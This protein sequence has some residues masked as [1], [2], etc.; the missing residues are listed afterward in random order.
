LDGAISLHRRLV[1][2]LEKLSDRVLARRPELRDMEL[3]ARQELSE[4]LRLH[5][6][7]AE[8]IEVKEV[9]LETH[10]ERASDWRRDL[11]VLR[12]SKGEVETGL[13]ELRT[14][15]EEDPEDMWR[16]VA[17]G[18]ESRREGRFAESQEALDQALM[19]GGE[20]SD[21]KDLASVHYQRFLLFKEMGSLDDAVAAWDS[22]VGLEPEVGST[23]REVYDML[24]SAGRFSE[25]RRYVD[26]DDNELQA[27]FQR[28]LLAHL[29]GSEAQ[30]KREWRAVAELDPE[31]FESGHD[32]WAEA[33]LRLGDPE[34][35]LERMDRLLGRYGSARLSTMAGIAW[36]MH[37]DEQQAQK[38]FD[39]TIDILRRYRPPKHKLDS[40]DWRLLDSLVA[41]DELKRVLKPYFAVVETIWG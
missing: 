29:S 16:W 14:L 19:L 5:G 21:P 25:A 26:R 35:A 37:G 20:G 32:A 24:T 10:P 15:A 22:A 7:F 6:R 3:Q 12:I 13:T 23:V 27:G 36:A 8:A 18:A 34:P 30:A 4:M 28:G 11:A 2:K 17:L 33:V 9:L 41:D 40:A 38:A 31:G 39:Q 1:Q